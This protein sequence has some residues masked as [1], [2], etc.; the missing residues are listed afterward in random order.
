MDFNYESAAIIA[1]VNYTILTKK[2]YFKKITIWGN[3]RN[4]SEHVTLLESIYGR[5]PVASGGN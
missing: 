2:T 3:N 4:G 5:W 1:K